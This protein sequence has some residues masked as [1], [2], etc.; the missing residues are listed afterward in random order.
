[1][2]C[3]GFSGW[4]VIGDLVVLAVYVPPFAKARRMGCPDFF[5]WVV[6]GDLVVLAVLRPTLRKVREGWGTRAFR[7]SR[8]VGR[9]D[10][11]CWRFYVPPFAKARRM[12]CP[13]FFGWVVIGDLVVLA[14]LRPTLREGAKMGCPGFCGSLRGEGSRYFF[15]GGGRYLRIRFRWGRVRRWRS[16]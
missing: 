1:M 5:G 15:R 7:V 9:R 10:W 16:A 2:G 11:W 3:P 4:V 6:I 14:V 12:R 8:S 13:G